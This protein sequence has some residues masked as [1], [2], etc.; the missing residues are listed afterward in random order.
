M[1]GRP[2]YV[3]VPP[4]ALRARCLARLPGAAAVDP[5]GGLAALGAEPPGVLLVDPEATGAAALARAAAA[6]QASGGWSVCT[7]SQTGHGEVEAR[8]LSIGASHSLDD[9]ARFAGCD[10]RNGDLLDLHGVL[11]EVAR[12]RHDLNNPLTSAMAEV[13]ILLMDAPGEAAEE[14]LLVIQEQLRRM[15]DRLLDTRHLRPL[16]RSGC[17]PK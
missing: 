15:R 11:C 12:A 8:T 3:A 4:G 2:I 17:N 6:L 7:L 9:V 13:Q 1:S 5:A 10:P 14:S 16:S